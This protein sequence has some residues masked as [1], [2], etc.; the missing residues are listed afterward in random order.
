MGFPWFSDAVQLLLI[1]LEQQ[2]S[3]AT[4]DHRNKFCCTCFGDALQYN[5]KGSFCFL[6]HHLT[7]KSISKHVDPL[8]P[9][10]IPF[11][12]FLAQRGLPMTF[13]SCRVS[14]CWFS[15]L[16]WSLDDQEQP[17]CFQSCGFRFVDSTIR[18]KELGSWFHLQALNMKRQ[19]VFL[20]S[21]QSAKLF[22]R[23]SMIREGSV[24]D[25]FRSRS[26]KTLVSFWAKPPHG[27]T[28]C[29]WYV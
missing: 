2:H 9:S 21:W 7:G 13:R 25:W 22:D 17:C 24:S 19:F 5:F 14:N 11:K 4:M 18:W 26:L 12:V 20:C 27:A 8:Q 3:L 28:H 29:D 16:V 6:L 10:T 1:S 23:F 15:L